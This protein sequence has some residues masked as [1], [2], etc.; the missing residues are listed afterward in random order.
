MPA[1]HRMPIVYLVVA[2]AATAYAVSS[3]VQAGPPGPVSGSEA[4]DG[5][6]G[7]DSAPSAAVL[8]PAP[9]ETSAPDPIL[10]T[11]AGLRRKIL[12]QELG[13]VAKGAGADDATPLDYLSIHFVYGEGP[14]VLEIGPGAGPPLGWVK[15]ASTLEWDTRLM[16]RPTARRGRPPLVIYRDK[17]CLLDNLAGR[18]CRRHMDRCPTEGE[19]SAASES[20]PPPAFGLPI[21]STETIPQPDGSSR[22][23]HEVASPVRDRAAPTRPAEPPLDLRPLLQSIYLAVAIDTT[24][25]M[26][27]TIAAA[28]AFAADLAEQVKGRYGDVTLRLALVEFRD[29]S[30][31]FGY[32]VRIATN[33]AD[34]PRFL[35]A[36]GKI[37][38]AREGDGTVDERVLDGVEASL[39][40]SVGGAQGRPHLSWPT[41]RPGDLATKMLVLIGDAPDHDRDLARAA[42]LAEAAKTAGITIASVRIDRPGALSRD[43]ARRYREQWH[44]LAEGSFLPRDRDRGFAE[45]IGPIEAELGGEV[46][47]APR[48]QAILDDRV[49]YA[50]DL[51]ALA[52]AEAEG[53]LVEYTNRQGIPVAGLLPVLSDLH[54]GEEAPRSRPDPRHDGRKA[55]SLRRG[56]IAETS[57]GTRFVE[58]E[59]LMTRDELDQLVDELRGLEQAAVGSAR[60]L[61]DLLRIGTAALSG[62]SAFL[63]ADRGDKT[64]AEHLRARQGLPPAR[65]D[66]LLMRTQA[67]LLQADDATRA[68]LDARLRSALVKL[69]ERRNAGDWDDPRR[70]VEGMA[71][72]PYEWLD[73]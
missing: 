28:R 58:L 62:E 71:G 44:A 30:P 66:S 2:L 21:L 40:P 14:G 52:A 29:R 3:W 32:D 39:P 16:A 67:D 68:A 70:T 53:K 46:A 33:F 63:A 60:D 61:E 8:P 19:E 59:I 4:G 27:S 51:A 54:R 12:I 50:R 42:R 9:I 10:R 6:A 65:R 25:S 34:P 49:E 23:I 35:A 72:V 11:K 7:A 5:A 43:E 56:W 18:T 15:A 41:G 69:I 64:F 36:L 38:A 55:S 26:G 13:A 24:A 45:R 17:E 22:T 1:L 31:A 48:L 73:W 37:A 57:G 20:D 47:L